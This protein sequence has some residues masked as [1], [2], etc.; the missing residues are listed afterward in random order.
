MQLFNKEQ[1]IK[2]RDHCNS[3]IG[4]PFDDEL[5]IT[6]IWIIPE[7]QDIQSIA[8][9]YQNGTMSKDIAETYGKD[10]NLQIRVLSSE[11]LKSSKILASKDVSKFLTNDQ[12]QQIL[13]SP[14]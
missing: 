2:L 9:L 1:A 8:Q 4:Q 13:N 12:I 14:T 11:S 10:R 3:L 6:N 5:R 7:D